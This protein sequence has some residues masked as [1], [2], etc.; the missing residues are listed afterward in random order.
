MGGEVKLKLPKRIEGESPSA[1]DLFVSDT[2]PSNF[3]ATV[4]VLPFLTP[5]DV[6]VWGVRHFMKH[7]EMSPNGRPAYVE[8]FASVVF[9]TL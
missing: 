6:L 9:R 1:V 3:V 2:K 7:S 8:C 5:P 4:A